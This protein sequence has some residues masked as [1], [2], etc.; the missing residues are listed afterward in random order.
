MKRSHMASF[1][2]GLLFAMG[3]GISGMTDPKKV[4]GFLDPADGWDPSLALVMVGA[5]G[6]HFVF[7]RRAI[8]GGKPLLAERFEIP[9]ITAIDLRLIAG[10]ALFGVGWG[11]AGYCPGPALASLAAPS[12]GL[13]A[14]L[15][16]MLAGMA[17]FTFLP[18]RS[19]SARSDA[20]LL[21]PPPKSDAADA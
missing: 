21:H 4:V 14:F 9:R 17:V 11:I 12:A 15:I 19:S 13:V 16:A 8:S 3:L 5:I 1:A 10:A 2:A 6:V 7:A 20:E 18:S